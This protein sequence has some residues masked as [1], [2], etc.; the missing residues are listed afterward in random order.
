MFRKE[1]GQQAVGLPAAKM[2]KQKAQSVRLLSD[3][4]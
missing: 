3:Q 4:Q 1:L 2:L